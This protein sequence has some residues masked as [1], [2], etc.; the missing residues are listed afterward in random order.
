MSDE[1][2]TIRVIGFEDAEIIKA[3]VRD[4]TAEI[5]RLQDLLALRDAEIARLKE[6]NAS[7]S[8]EVWEEAAKICDDYSPL[9][10]DA[11]LYSIERS[12]VRTIAAICRSR[13]S[14]ALQREDFGEETSS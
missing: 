3:W 2:K 1:P 10:S 9:T 12:V 6:A 5:H 7:R 11:T 4:V 14:P 13:S 8:Q